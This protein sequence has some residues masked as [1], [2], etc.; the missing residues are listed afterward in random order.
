MTNRQRRYAYL[1]PA[2][3]VGVCLIQPAFSAPNPFRGTTGEPMKQ[4]DLDALTAA[5]NHLLDRPQLV[6]GGTE[7]W[8]NPASGA[9][10]T[11]TAG[12]ALTRHNLSCRI[13]QYKIV[14]PGTRPARNFSTTW[15]KTR[16]GW[17]LG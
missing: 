16:D 14:G 8:T 9:G 4:D 11:I 17:K 3:L 12:K 15:C 7:T 6:P 13:V 2:F 5:T 10:G 1:L